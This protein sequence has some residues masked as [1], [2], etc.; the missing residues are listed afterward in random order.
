M[1]EIDD[2]K[3]EHDVETYDQYVGAHVRVPIGDE[4][5]SGKVVRCK[6]ELDG[7]VKGQADASSMLETRAYE[8][9]FPDGH[10]DEYIAN[11]I[12]ENMYAQCD[13]EEIQYNIMG[14]IVDHKTDIHAVEP[15]DM[16]I[17]H[18]SNKKVRK[19]TKGSNLCVEWKDG[20]TIWERLVD[21]KESN[22]V[23]VAEYSA[24]KSLLYTPAF[25][26]WA[27]YVLKKRSRIIAAVPKCYHKR[28]HKFGI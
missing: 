12:A 23:D 17:K 9:E 21:L 6:R 10:S 11:V 4:I 16:Y 27:P 28:T 2:I 18:G 22:P 13:I 20:T 19:T 24:A 3:E 8:I 15:A 7:T 14:G 1:P 25:V 5:R 26:W